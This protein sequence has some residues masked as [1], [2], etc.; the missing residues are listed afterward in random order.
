[1]HFFYWN[2]LVFLPLDPDP[3]SQYGSGSTK[4][5]N[6]DPIRIRIH[7]P[8]WDHN[9]IFTNK[10]GFWCQFYYRNYDLNFCTS[11]FSTVTGTG[12]EP[13]TSAAV[14]LKRWSNGR[15]AIVIPYKL[16]PQLIA[17]HVREGYPHRS[18]ILNHHDLLLTKQIPV[19]IFTLQ[20][21]RTAKRYKNYLDDEKIRN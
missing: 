1:V 20:G 21:F 17:P 3:D 5:L 9:F 8:V 4:S 16:W 15:F 19:S 18:Y 14:Y 12:M 11:I 7:I 2:F 10:L 13:K 6:P